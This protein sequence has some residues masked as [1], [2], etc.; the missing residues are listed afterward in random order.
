[1]LWV[2][3]EAPELDAETRE[4]KVVAELRCYRWKRRERCRPREGSYARGERG[5]LGVEDWAGA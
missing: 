4:L 1:M 2:E 3:S 5:R